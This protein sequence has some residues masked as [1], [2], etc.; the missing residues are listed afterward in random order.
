MKNTSNFLLSVVIP[1]FN[2]EAALE[3]LLKSLSQSL[4]PYAKNYEVIFINDGSTD[5]TLNTLLDLQKSYKN[6]KIINLSRNFG[7]EAALSA[8]FHK[9][10]GD[11]IVPMDADLQ[12]PPALIGEMIKKWRQGFDIVLARRSDRQDSFFKNLSAKLFYKIINSLSDTPIYRDVGDFRLFNRKVLDVIN[13]FTERNRMMKGLLSWPG[14]K[15]SYVNYIRPNRKQ[16]KSHL[17]FFK[18]S[19]IALDGIFSLSSLPLKIWTY[20]GLF[21]SSLSLIYALFLIIR[22]TIYGIDVPGYASIMVSILFMGGI[23]LLCIGILAEYIARIY[24]ET[25]GRPLYIIDE[26][27]EEK[28]HKAKKN[29]K[30]SVKNK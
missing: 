5:N 30:V 23:Q 16:G 8:G 21:I 18:L 29:S 10:T 4:Q 24:D 1:V 28:L 15:I 19:K 3:L 14:F 25:K 7:K 27:Y 12:D 6:I 22:T 2:E 20:I 17:N 26:I 9:A 11:I 13:Q